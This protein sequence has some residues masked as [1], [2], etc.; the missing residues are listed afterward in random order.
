MHLGVPAGRSGTDTRRWS[1]RCIQPGWVIS[2]PVAGV[3]EQD[4]TAQGGGRAGGPVSVEGDRLDRGALGRVGRVKG[5]SADV[6]NGAPAPTHSKAALALTVSSV[7]PAPPP[8]GGDKDDELSAARTTTSSSAETACWTTWMRAW[9]RTYSTVW[10]NMRYRRLPCARQHD[11]RQ[12]GQRR[13]RPRRGRR[14]R[15]YCET[16]STPSAWVMTPFSAT[17]RTTHGRRKRHRRT[18]RQGRTGRRN[19]DDLLDRNN[20]FE[21]L[22]A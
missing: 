1:R 9:A 16:S 20:N 15:H 6:L 19:G 17:K 3:V 18:V 12:F 8:Y 13:Q 7:A 2:L 10:R 5:K 14:R 4:V 21:G 11:H 22:P